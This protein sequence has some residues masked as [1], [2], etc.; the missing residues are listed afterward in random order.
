MKRTALT[1][2][3][4]IRMARSQFGGIYIIVEGSTDVKVYKGLTVEGEVRFIDAREK[5]V[6][7]EAIRLLN[8]DHQTGVLA[9]A[10]ADFD[11]LPP[12]QLFN[13]PNLLYC[14]HHDGETMLIDSPALE[15]VLRELGSSEKIRA[16]EQGGTRVRTHLLNSGRLIAR[17]AAFVVDRW[18]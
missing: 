9:I 4:E 5:S 11:R 15:K 6:L 3:N 2:A 7:V 13:E 14:D 1:I 10:D 12:L 17:L 16:V 18:T 8:A